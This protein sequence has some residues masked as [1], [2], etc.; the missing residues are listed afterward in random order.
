M[1]EPF[2]FINSSTSDDERPVLWQRKGI[3]LARCRG[4]TG[5]ADYKPEI[6]D[7]KMARGSGDDVFDV[8]WIEEFEVLS[9]AERAFFAAQR[10]G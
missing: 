9:R 10:K 5:Q 6:P 1:A 3:T 8:G 4:A 2:K 7:G